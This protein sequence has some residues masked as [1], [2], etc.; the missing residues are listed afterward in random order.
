MGWNIFKPHWMCCAVL[1]HFRPYNAHC[2]CY[3][4][5]LHAHDDPDVHL[6]CLIQHLKDLQAL[7]LHVTFVPNYHMSLYLPHF[8][9][10]FSPVHSW[11]CF[12]F[13]HLINDYSAIIKL[14]STLLTRQFT[15]HLCCHQDKWSQCYSILSWRYSGS[16]IGLHEQTV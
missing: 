5:H 14:V 2:F 3:L 15:A 7:H 8:F 12:L 16:N 6:S 4:P 13:E 9:H 1:S 11:W 10:L